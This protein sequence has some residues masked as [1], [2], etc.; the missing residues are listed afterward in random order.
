EFEAYLRS[1]NTP[2]VTI[3]NRVSEEWDYV[4][5]DDRQAMKEAATHVLSKG[6]RHI[7]YICPPL[8]YRGKTNIY[9]QEERYQGCLEALEE[10]DYETTLTVIEEKDYIDALRRIPLEDQRTAI[11]CSCD[12]YA[13]EVLHNVQHER[14][15]SVP[16]DV[17]I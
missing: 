17:G 11:M 7:V 12:A 16:D 2:L 1:L 9:T 15:L 13:L 6:Y 4:G 8:A 10:V 5:I 14:K 3:C